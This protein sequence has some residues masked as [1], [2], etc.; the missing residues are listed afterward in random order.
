MPKR[1]HTYTVSGMS[2]DHCALSVRQEVAGLAGVDNVDVEL[3]SG[4][5]TVT[6]AGFADEDVRKAAGSA[7]YALTA[8]SAN[9]DS[10]GGAV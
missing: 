9:G 1:E 2:C 10:D 8:A 5:L 6:G 7:G 3:A 4:Q